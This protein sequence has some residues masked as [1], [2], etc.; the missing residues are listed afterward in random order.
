MIIVVITDIRQIMQCE[1]TT[2]ISRKMS[3]Y[4]DSLWHRHIVAD[5]PRVRFFSGELHF[6]S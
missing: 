4:L 3:A 5:K 1:G 2:K 6:I